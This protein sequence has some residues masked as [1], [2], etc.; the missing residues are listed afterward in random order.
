[1]L[2]RKKI[3]M[4]ALISPIICFLLSVFVLGFVM[5]S[6]WYVQV[7]Q[8]KQ[9]KHD[10]GNIRYTEMGD[11]DHA[12]IFLHGFNAQINLWNDVW[13]NMQGCTHAIRLDIPGFGGSEWHT[14]SYHLNEQEKRILAFINE[15][16]L[17]KVTLVGTSMGASLAVIIAARHPSLVRNLVLMAPS[18][19]PGSLHYPGIFGKLIKQGSLNRYAIWIANARMYQWIFPNSIA[20]QSL[21]TAASYNQEWVDELVK[22]EIPVAVLWSAGD[23]TV[24]YRYAK[25]VVEKIQSVQLIRLDESVGHSAPTKLAGPIARLS[26]ALA[27][28]QKIETIN[29]LTPI[30]IDIFGSTSI[31]STIQE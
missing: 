5:P 1:M 20:L 2:L 24:P 23:K 26:C 27:P 22:I 8:A 17:K 10:Q 30:L 7:D 4:L 29:Q 11:G 12:V 13:S 6:S 14:N 9:W 3:I 31:Q 19:Y 28:S 25:P 21:T 16:K 15:K 18:G